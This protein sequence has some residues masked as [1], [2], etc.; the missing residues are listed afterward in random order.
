MKVAVSRWAMRLSIIGLCSFAIAGPHRFVFA[1]KTP[2]VYV[3]PIDGIIDLGIAPFVQRVLNEATHT[4]ESVLEQLGLAG[5][6]VRRASP[7]WV[8][9]LV[10]FLTPP[11]VSSLL[12]T[13]GMLGIILELRTPG[14][15]LPGA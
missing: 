13:I 3:A 12:I 5:V 6:Q 11:V 14:L 1:Q 9:N 4:V 15:G 8:E 2:A 10:R 7:N